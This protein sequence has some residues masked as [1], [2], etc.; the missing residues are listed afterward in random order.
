M[1]M[2]FQIIFFLDTN[3]FL[4]VLNALSEHDFERHTPSPILSFRSDDPTLGAYDEK[5]LE[6]YPIQVNSC[7]M[8]PCSISE[9]ITYNS[10][11]KITYV[12]MY[13]ILLCVVNKHT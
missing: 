8:S 1:Q 12:P 11:L 2:N 4:K 9:M 7:M 13:I 5:T 6:H 10:K 3:P